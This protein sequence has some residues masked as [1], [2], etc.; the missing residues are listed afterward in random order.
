[1]CVG[2]MGVGV[3]RVLSKRLM[4]LM[5]ILLPNSFGMIGKFLNTQSEKTSVF[6]TILEEISIHI[7]TY[8]S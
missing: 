4:I 5:I 7:H 3:G 8:F 1:M 2:G 6:G